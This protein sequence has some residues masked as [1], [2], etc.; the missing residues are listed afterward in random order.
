[1]FSK[2]RLSCANIEINTV[3]L[4]EILYLTYTGNFY[5]LI[6]LPGREIYFLGLDKNFT[7]QPFVVMG[8]DEYLLFPTRIST[9]SRICIDYNG[10][11]P[12][13]CTN[14]VLYSYKKHTKN[15]IRSYH[16]LTTCTWYNY[17][18]HETWFMIEFAQLHCNIF[19]STSTKFTYWIIP[20]IHMYIVHEGNWKLTPTRCGC[21]NTLSY[22]Y[23][24]HKVFSPLPPD[25]GNFALGRGLILRQNLF[26][27]CPNVY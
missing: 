15:R 27:Y 21:S 3:H 12:D 18:K 5:F 20:D 24:R 1:M 23:L 8:D 6:L 2:S 25:G 16:A 10:V 26:N 19:Y 9:N 7:C 13:T 4:H 11:L 17:Q 14:K 22:Y